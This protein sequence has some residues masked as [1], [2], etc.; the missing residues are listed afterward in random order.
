ML[1]QTQIATVWP[2]YRRWLERFPTLAAVAQAELDE[3]LKLWEGL[4]YYSRARNIHRTAQFVQ[5]NFDG[6]FPKQRN[7]LIKLPGIGPYTAAAIAS[8]AF[9]EAVPLIDGNVLRVYSRLTCLSNPTNT[10]RTKHR[11]TAILSHWLPADQAGAFNQALMDLGREICIPQQPRCT[12]CPVA[13]YC[14]ALV[15][16]QV[17]RFPLKV[18]RPRV[19][20][21][22]IVV[23]LIHK[24]DR[25]LIQKRPEQGLLGGLWEFPG[26]KVEPGETREEALLRELREETGLAVSLTQEIGTIKHAYTHFKITLSAWHCQWQ[27][28]TAKIFAATENRWI[29]LQEID[30]YAFPGANRKIL[31]LLN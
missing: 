3:I 16:D 20:H 22:D 23:G 30:D 10:P 31:K 12:E 2:Y 29:K 13:E 7:E 19:P 8:I 14:Q 27:A 9:G 26:G 11:V 5:R 18:H 25:V 21:Y 24:D 17:D 4:G 15:R 1:Q 6:K 28:G